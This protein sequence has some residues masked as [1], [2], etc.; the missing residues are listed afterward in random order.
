MDK[1]HSYC[2]QLLYRV[3]FHITFTKIYLRVILFDTTPELVVSFRQ[4]II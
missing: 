4:L 1:E 2:L 3:I